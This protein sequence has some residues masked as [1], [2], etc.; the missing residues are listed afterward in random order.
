V[1][2]PDASRGAAYGAGFESGRRT[3][4]VPRTPGLSAVSCSSALSSPSG[5]RGVPSTPPSGI[6]GGSVLLGA[7]LLNPDWW[8]VAL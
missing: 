5:A 1:S 7:V 4:A 8:L 2:N 6:V 3:A